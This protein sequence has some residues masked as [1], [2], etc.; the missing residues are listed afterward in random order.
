VIAAL[1]APTTI[2]CP[3]TPVFATATAVDACGSA[4]TLT[5]NDV[6]TNGACAGQYSVTRTWTATDACGNTSTASQTINVQDITAPVVT[7]TGN[8]SVAP[9]NALCTYKLTGT[10]W[11]ATATDNCSS[12]TIKYT[13]SGATTS[14]PGAFTTLNNVVF[15]AGLTT[16]TAIAYD[17]CNNASIPCTFTVTVTSPLAATSTTPNRQLYYGFSLDQ[18]S[19]ITTT[20]TGGTGPY[21]IV[22]TMDRP[23]KCNQVNSVGDETFVGGAGTS[24]S[25][26]VTCPTSGNAT[27]APVV[28][29][30]GVSTFSITVK[31]MVDAVIKVTV[32]DVFGCVVMDTTKIWAEDVRCFAGNSNNAKVKLC[33]INNGNGCG[34]ICVDESAVQTHLNHGDFLGNCTSNC[35][36]PPVYLV[37]PPAEDSIAVLAVD[38]DAPFKVNVSP[39]PTTH[40]FKMVVE[41]ES[42]EPIQIRIYDVLGSRIDQLN[43][44]NRNTVITLGDKYRGGT[45]FAEVLQGKNRKVVKLIKLN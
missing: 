32:T 31:L 19:V 12:T 26:N 42:R 11:N 9:N 24:S 17:A 43:N 35:I 33:H 38:K 2:N 21:T 27:L 5:S 41:S 6:T 23:L 18:T 30:N 45:F 22:Y 34:A 13:L 8:K 44:Q 10:T 15:S 3:A 36:A 29:A 40:Q 7:C 39:N 1:P 16:V 14:A 28:T 20:P 4:F 37:M 25:V